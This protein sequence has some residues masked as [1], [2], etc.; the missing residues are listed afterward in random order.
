MNI[1]QYFILSMWITSCCHQS[2]SSKHYALQ[3]YNGTQ[4]RENKLNFLGIKSLSWQEYSNL[5]VIEFYIGDTKHISFLEI[6][7]EPILIRKYVTI[8]KYAP[9]FMCFYS[10]IRISSFDF[11]LLDEF[12][13]A[14]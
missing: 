1:K 8:F 13:L 12:I 6:S 3:Q 2:I 9:Y 10:R 5:H 7:L 14:A 4:D 11:F